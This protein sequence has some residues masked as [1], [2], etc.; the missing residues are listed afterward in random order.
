MTQTFTQKHT[1]WSELFSKVERLFLNLRDSKYVRP[2]FFLHIYN[3]PALA[4]HN[5]N[6]M[7]SGLYDVRASTPKS[8][9]TTPTK[10]AKKL[11]NIPKHN[12]DKD[13]VKN[14]R[15]MQNLGD[16]KDNIPEWK[17]NKNTGV[18]SFWYQNQAS[19]E[20]NTRE[21]ERMNN[22]P[23]QRR[24]GKDLHKFSESYRPEDETEGVWFGGKSRKGRKGG[25][26]K[27]TT[28]KRRSIRKKNNARQKSTRVQSKRRGK[29]N[30]N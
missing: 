6:E 23:F 24:Q 1:S 8:L 20:R 19:K 12:L 27:K 11:S 3:M 29:K 16:M 17:M 15:P 13:V 9:S 14:N 22:P 26:S 5:P 18:E 30:A 7:G 21:F 2:N 25:K 28:K 10:P 4:L